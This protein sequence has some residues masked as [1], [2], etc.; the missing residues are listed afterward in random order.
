MNDP[1]N[2][3]FKP[4]GIIEVQ[5]DGHTELYAGSNAKWWLEQ[6]M[7]F[8]GAAPLSRCAPQARKRKVSAGKI[9]FRSKDFE[10][11]S[12]KYIVVRSLY[13]GKAISKNR[14]GR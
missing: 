12:N 8:S 7:R 6:Q 14:S 5:N 1:K 13:D 9:D 3:E 4:G 10:I 2:F 11:H